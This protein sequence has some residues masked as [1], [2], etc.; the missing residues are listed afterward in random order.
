MVWQMVILV[1]EAVWRLRDNDAG[2]MELRVVIGDGCER[3]GWGRGYRDAGE[4]EE[5]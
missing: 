1:G 2:L 3:W 5:R 4:R